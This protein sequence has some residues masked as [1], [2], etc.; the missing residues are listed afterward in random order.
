[1]IRIYVTSDPV[2]L[3][4]LESILEADGISCLV[5][6]RFLGG[7][8]GE[9]PLNEAWPEL[10]VVDAEDERRARQLIEQA[11]R[12][13]QPVAAWHCPG[14]RELI[15]GQFAQCWQCGE[16]RDPLSTG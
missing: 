9:L 8:I 11:L 7:A 12:P 5:R 1:M 10:W 15:E 4:W 2:Q 3:G 13:A 14:C 16:S 6:N